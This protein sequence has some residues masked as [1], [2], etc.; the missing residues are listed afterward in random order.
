MYISGSPPHS[1]DPPPVN[2]LYLGYQL[3]VMRYLIPPPVSV[4][5]L[6]NGIRRA[7]S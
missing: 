4:F 3:M 6:R 1:S 5:Y 7:T 2:V